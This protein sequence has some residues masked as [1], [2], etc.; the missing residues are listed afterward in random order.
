[1][2]ITYEDKDVLIRYS[3]PGYSPEKESQRLRIIT[4]QIQKANESLSQHRKN[5]IS[6]CN[7]QAFALVLHRL[8]ARNQ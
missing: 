8:Q 2:P 3:A 5:R 6:R 7:S 4:D 1:M